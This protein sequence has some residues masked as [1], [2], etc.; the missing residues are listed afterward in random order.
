MGLPYKND[1]QTHGWWLW[2]LGL[3]LAKPQNRRGLLHHDAR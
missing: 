2:F 1:A 3:S